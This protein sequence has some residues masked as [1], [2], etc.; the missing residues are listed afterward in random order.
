MIQSPDIGSRII[1]VDIGGANIKVADASG[2]AI[3][4]P[5][6]MW[7]D[8][9]ALG[10]ALQ[11]L[12]ADFDASTDST[13]PARVSDSLGI[14]SSPLDS[15]LAITMTGEMADC[16][17][18]RQEGVKV[19]LES[20][21]SQFPERNLYIYSTD[22]CWL[23]PKQSKADPWRVAASNWVALANWALRSGVVDSQSIAA[24]IDVGSTTVDI[25]PVKQGQL[26]TAAK[27]D[28]DRLQLGQ[29]VYTGMERSA[30]ASIVSELRFD[31][32][33]CPVVAEQFATSGDAYLVL[34]L[35]EEQPEAVDSADGKPKTVHFARARLARMIGED[36]DRIGVEAIESLAWQIIDAQAAK[37]T[38]ALKRNLAA[39]EPHETTP[40]K[41]LVSGHGSPLLRRV[42]ENC[43][44]ENL[45]WDYLIE[46][47]PPSASRAAPAVAVAWLLEKALKSEN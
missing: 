26:A 39:S 45:H 30:I 34:G 1:G 37:I 18:S 40:K 6:P 44:R 42:Q 16:F 14:P 21:A 32:A 36:T 11:S 33:V 7:T 47:I 35:V 22:D 27:T 9:D 19:I 41:I 4:I 2:K 13:A 38:A 8:C 43:K 46:R 25:I 29:L 3:S 31:G 5:F 20:V 17:A 15:L 28:R 23:T 24:I 12:L 10:S